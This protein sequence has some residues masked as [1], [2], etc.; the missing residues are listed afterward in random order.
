M[1]IVIL[2]LAASLGVFCGGGSPTAPVTGSGLETV[3]LAPGQST[4]VFDGTATLTFDRVVSDNRCPVDVQCITAGEAVVEVTVET[5]TGK[6]V[7][8]LSSSGTKN[9]AVAGSV[10]LRL[11]DVK[12]EPDSNVRINPADYRIT[13]EVRRT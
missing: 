4:A 11:T 9:E 2:A 6:S 5:R 8:E 7:V 1:R 13:L 3:T 12:P 10:R